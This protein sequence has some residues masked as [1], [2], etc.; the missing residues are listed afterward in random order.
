MKQKVWYWDKDDKQRAGYFVRTIEKGKYFGLIEVESSVGN[1][2]RV[3]PDRVEFMEE[4]E[5]GK[6]TTAS[7]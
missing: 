1:L 3:S 7:S 2:C 6:C 5:E 4:E